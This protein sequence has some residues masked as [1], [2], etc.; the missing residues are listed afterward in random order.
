M[1]RTTNALIAGLFLCP[2]FSL[3]VHAQSVITEQEAQAI[4]VDAYIYLY[5][6]VTMDVTRK[7][8]TNHDPGPESSAAR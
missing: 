1:I 4:A 7:Q 8:I 2:I 3:A 5:P 6:L